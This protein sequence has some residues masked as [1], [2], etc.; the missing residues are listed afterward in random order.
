MSAME[1]KPDIVCISS[2]D[3][4]FI[5]QG[6]QEIMSRL[7]ADGHRVLFIEN[8][9]VRAP[10]MRDLP[11]VRQRVR[12]WWRGTKGFRAGAAESVH[13]LAAAAAVALPAPLALDQPVRADAG[14][15]AVDAMR[16]G[17]SSR[18]PGRFCRR[19][20]RAICSAAIDPQPDDLL[21][22]RRLRVELRRAR[23]GLSRAK[24]G[25]SGT[26]IWSSSP[27]S[28]FV[29]ARRA[30]AI[31]CICSRSAS[32]SSASM[33]PVAALTRSRRT[34]RRSARPVIGYVGG[35]HQ[36]IDQDLL[37]GS[38]GGDAGRDV[39]AHRPGADRRRPGCGSAPISTCSACASI[40]SCRAT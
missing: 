11:R 36:W 18:S 1:R 8:T 10:N 25:C 33:R 21:L 9:G 14:D 15:P 37:V 3:W 35:L 19:R 13:L 30:S 27:P 16:P 38:R 32:A 2:I 39:R 6:H 7:A 12:N 26:P 40:T 29:S 24:S 17:S 4:D 34:W 23:S 31:A 5:W 22:H 28:G 20:S